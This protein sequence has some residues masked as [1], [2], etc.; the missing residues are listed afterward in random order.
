MYGVFPNVQNVWRL[1]KRDVVSHD[2]D[3]RQAENGKN[4]KKTIHVWS[5]LKKHR[6]IPGLPAHG[7]FKRDFSTV[8]KSFLHYRVSI[9]TRHVLREPFDTYG[10]MQQ[11][12]FDA[13]DA[14]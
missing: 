3:E 6:G 12:D 5:F 13:L 10:I 4:V 8:N 11:A 1:S 14:L 9:A 7:A 2:A